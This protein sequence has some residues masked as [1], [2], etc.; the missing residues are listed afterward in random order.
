[1]GR[2][3]RDGEWDKCNF[4]LN[5]CKKAG[6]CNKCKQCKKHCN[7]KFIKREKAKKKT[8][9]VKKKRVLQTITNQK[10]DRVHRSNYKK[11]N[12]KMAENI[13]ELTT[14]LGNL[15]IFDETEDRLQQIL[16]ILEI[17]KP[18]NYPG[19]RTL[20]KALS[21]KDVPERGW[22]VR[23][24]TKKICIGKLFISNYAAFFYRK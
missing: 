5:L 8:N 10:V 24:K 2:K 21:K 4:D 20:A 22:K 15:Q 6:K 11:V 14:D 13:A 18:Q 16:D 9:P 12:D 7:C 1:M 3:P 17:E 23:M 19:K